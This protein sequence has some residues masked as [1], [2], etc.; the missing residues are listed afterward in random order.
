MAS[1]APDCKEYRLFASNFPV[2]DEQLRTA[3][4]AYG[5]MRRSVRDFSDTGDVCSSEYL[6]YLVTTCRF[7]DWLLNTTPLSAR[8]L[9]FAYAGKE[10]NCIWYE[11]IAR[12]HDCAAAFLWS[13]AVEERLRDIANDRRIE[14]RQ[15]A[16]CII[17]LLKYCQDVA[18]KEWK[19]A[20]ALPE[21]YERAY[22]IKL[23][24]WCRAY[25]MFSYGMIK[26]K[27]KGFDAKSIQALKRI[28]YLFTARNLLADQ[29]SSLK[30]SKPAT[31]FSNGS[32]TLKHDCCIRLTDTQPFN[33]DKRKKCIKLSL[34]WCE[35]LDT[36]FLL[37]AS[38]YFGYLDVHG[39]VVAL[40]QM[41][42]CRGRSVPQLDKVTE[43]NND[44]HHHPVPDPKDIIKAMEDVWL[45]KPK[46]T[47]L[48]GE[49]PLK[50]PNDASS[51]FF[52]PPDHSLI[53]QGTQ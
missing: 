45:L 28:N 14:Q 36:E 47:M 10:S 51:L 37:V 41:A 39:N 7:A 22:G 18:F 21:Q 19:D 8:P 4:N 42:E 26:E 25:A 50:V 38:E 27:A 12:V 53:G 15:T 5:D 11:L 33:S 34:T 32:D 16:R 43:S 3:L 20:P 24:K 31:A 35:K 49:D 29:S 44:I 40:L 17:G 48:Q 13:A 30:I 9:L 2:K 52:I 6:A 46:Y 1:E 23:Y